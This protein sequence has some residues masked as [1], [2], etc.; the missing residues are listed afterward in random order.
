MSIFKRFGSVAVALSVLAGFALADAGTAAAKDYRYS[1]QSLVLQQ[2]D[3]NHDGQL[4]SKEAKR[5]RKSGWQ[6]T[7]AGTW[8]PPR[9]SGWAQTNA[10]NWVQVPYNNNS[11]WAQTNAGTWVRVPTNQ[12]PYQNNGNYRW[13]QTNAGTWV[14]VPVTNQNQH[15]W[16]NDQHDHGNN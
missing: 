4:S 2:F 16:K 11:G 3:R 7:N 1:N 15:E 5:A 6:Q 14:K 12:A 8:V 13:A 9:N 10:G